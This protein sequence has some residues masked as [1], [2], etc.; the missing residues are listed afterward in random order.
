EQI[1][2]RSRL[3]PIIEQ[4]GLYTSIRSRRTMDE[5]IAKLQTS[6]LIT[7]IEPMQKTR[8]SSLPKFHIDVTLET[9]KL[10]QKIC[11]EISSMFMEQNTRS[12]EQQTAQTTSFLTEQLD[13][14]KA[15]LDEQDTRLAKFK[16]R[17]LDALPDQEQ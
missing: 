8:G 9:P 6:I 13:Q 3:Q 5:L 15:K 16:T 17:Y 12:R 4:F 11:T 10:A 1:L 14:A 2:S 7:P